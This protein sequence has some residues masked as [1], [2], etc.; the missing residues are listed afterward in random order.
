[1]NLYLCLSLIISLLAPVPTVSS[2]ATKN[3]K[4]QVSRQSKAKRTVKRRRGNIRKTNRHR[5][6]QKYRL[7]RRRKAG[8]T[9]NRRKNSR[10]TT[11]NNKQVRKRS[12]NRE[13]RHRPNVTTT[14]APKRRPDPVR[15][16]DQP[17]P[18]STCPPYRNRCSCYRWKCCSQTQRWDPFIG[19]SSIIKNRLRI[20]CYDL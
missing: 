4:S 1:M 6:N 11:Y 13:G 8:G 7:Q 10:A 19:R 17:G 5:Q 12:T 14:Q 16:S 9:L 15:A 18:Q 3:R 20:Y 2:E